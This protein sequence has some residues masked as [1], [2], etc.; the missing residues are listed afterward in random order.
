MAGVGFDAIVIILR[1]NV[2]YTAIVVLGMQIHGAHELDARARKF[3]GGIISNLTN[4][5]RLFTRSKASLAHVDFQVGV[6]AIKAATA[7]N[8]LRKVRT[9]H[10]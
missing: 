5:E 9:E 3:L 7:L 2:D 8:V 10:K 4:H 6:A 1:D